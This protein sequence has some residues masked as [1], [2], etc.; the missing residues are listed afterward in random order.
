[1][2]MICCNEC[3][4]RACSPGVEVNA[5]AAEATMR[6]RAGVEV[7]LVRPEKTLW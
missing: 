5:E 6:A 3:R 1:M 4:V 7:G 2:E